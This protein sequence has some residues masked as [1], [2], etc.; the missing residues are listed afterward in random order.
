MF[1]ND[2]DVYVASFGAEYS[3]SDKVE[4]WLNRVTTIMRYTLNRLFAQSIESYEE[5]ARDCWI[6]GG[7]HR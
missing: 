7:R 3:C 2:N 5:K 4:N 1:S 6:F